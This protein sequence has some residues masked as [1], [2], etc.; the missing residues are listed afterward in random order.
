MA[1]G[2]L[3]RDQA[4]NVIRGAH[5]S[6]GQA[7]EYEFMMPLKNADQGD[8]LWE[9]K[10]TY[11][12]AVLVGPGQAYEGVSEDV[13]MSDQILIRI[14]SPSTLSMYLPPYV[15]REKGEKVAPPGSHGY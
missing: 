3:V 1:S 9:R 13:W 14:G 8:T 11:M 4:S 2:S 10:H 6:V 15:A 7:R 5:R 12:I